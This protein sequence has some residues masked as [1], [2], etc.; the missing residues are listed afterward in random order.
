MF[1]VNQKITLVTSSR[2]CFLQWMKNF[3]YLAGEC[4]HITKSVFFADYA[5]IWRHLVSAFQHCCILLPPAQR[6]KLQLL[7]RYLNKIATNACLTLHRQMSNRQLVSNLLG[8]WILQDHVFK[9]GSDSAANWFIFVAVFP[10]PAQCR[11]F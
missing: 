11:F 10:L 8:T 5:D 6:R 2:R 1:S 7:L 3:S 9:P 4:Q